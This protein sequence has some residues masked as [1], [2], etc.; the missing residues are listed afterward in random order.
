VGRLNKNVG[1]INETSP[2]LTRTLQQQT[3]QLHKKQ[4]PCL[5]RAAVP[6]RAQM[7]LVEILRLGVLARCPQPLLSSS[8]SLLIQGLALS[9][10]CPFCL[11][12]LCPSHTTV[13]QQNM[14]F[15]VV[16]AAS[17]SPLYWLAGVL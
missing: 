7:A 13:T 11:A 4:G 10:L 2:G 3:N 16:S 5:C 1:G 6:F 12:A 15:L 17:F 8:S 14:I 9:F